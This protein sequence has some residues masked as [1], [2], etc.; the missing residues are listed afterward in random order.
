MGGSTV[1]VLVY[2]S[3]SWKTDKQIVCTG[4]VT[5]N[6]VT[7]TYGLPKRTVLGPLLFSLMMNDL[8]SFVNSH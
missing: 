8:S 4:K 1:V 2:L 6:V 3:L 5:S 7:I